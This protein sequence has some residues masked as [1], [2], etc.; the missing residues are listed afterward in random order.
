MAYLV[1]IRFE[2]RLSRSSLFCPSQHTVRALHSHRKMNGMHVGNHWGHGTPSGLFASRSIFGS[3]SGAGPA[4]AQS[5]FRTKSKQ[6]RPGPP[7]RP[8]TV[9]P[10]FLTRSAFCS[11]GHVPNDAET[12]PRNHPI[13]T[14]PGGRPQGVSAQ[15][16]TTA[17]AEGQ[18]SNTPTP[19]PRIYARSVCQCSD[20][21][22]SKRAH[23]TL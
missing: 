1:R 2:N 15:R 17:P 6:L 13:P 3:A 19:Y 8:E 4:S 11:N 23:Y 9:L 10:S 20:V 12:R 14:A 16:N 22:S 5:A 18:S 7:A 21:Y